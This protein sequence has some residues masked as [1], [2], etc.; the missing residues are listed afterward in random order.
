MKAESWGAVV[1]AGFFLIVAPVYW[2]V[3]HEIIGTV[4]LLLSLA[5]C[6]ML[7]TYLTIQSRKIDPRPEDRK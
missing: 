3:S 6:A 2:F 1:L 5:F 4:A 7:A